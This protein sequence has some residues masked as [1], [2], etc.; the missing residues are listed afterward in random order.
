M[1]LSLERHMHFLHHRGILLV[2]I[3]DHFFCAIFWLFSLRH[4]RNPY[5]GCYLPFISVDFFLMAVISISF[6]LSH[7]G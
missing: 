3:F 4:S 6:I 1:E 2:Y 5:T 7:W